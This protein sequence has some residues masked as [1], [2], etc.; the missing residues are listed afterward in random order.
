MNKKYVISNT[1]PGYWN[2]EGFGGFYMVKYYDT[3][4]EAQ[5]VLDEID[6]KIIKKN[7]GYEI[8]EIY[9]IVA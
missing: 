8:K 4:E 6:P 9:T 7:V 5:K 1:N 2:G 3:R